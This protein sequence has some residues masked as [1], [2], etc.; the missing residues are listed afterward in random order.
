M[1]PELLE[2]YRNA[3]YE[4]HLPTGTIQLVVDQHCPG[5]HGLLCASGCARA[6][7]LTA[8]NPGSQLRADALNVTAQEQLELQLLRSGHNLFPGTA[9]DPAGQWPLEPGFLAIGI[10]RADALSVAREFHQTAILWC[11]ADAVPKLVE[12][13][14]AVR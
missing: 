1:T 12:T 3:T 11:E 8:F 5:L 7:W 14:Q 13:V 2:S 4:L 10:S 9:T 6:A